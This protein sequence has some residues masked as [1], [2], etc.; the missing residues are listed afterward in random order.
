MSTIAELVVGGSP[1][2]WEN[3]GFSLLSVSADETRFSLG[4]VVLVVRQAFPPG[5][6]S[7]TLATNESDV[8][9]DITIGDITI[10]GVATH[11]VGQAEIPKIAAA[12][13]GAIGCLGVDHVVIRT[14][15]LDIT[16]DAITHATGAPVKRVRDAG[17]G[18]QQAFHKLGDVVVEVVE[19]PQRVEATHLWGFVVNVADINGDAINLYAYTATSQM[20]KSYYTTT[21]FNINSTVTGTS[22]GEI[23][24]SMSAANTSNLSSG[25]Y[26]YD[27]KITSPELIVTRVVEGIVTVLPSVT[28]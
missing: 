10:D 1:E 16:C 8:V 3:F 25:R 28:R 22:N 21:A 11:V 19:S 5:M 20:R 26:V 18:V 12:G 7:W 6:V 4:D 2:P 15:S 13:V 14:N 23:T 17:S 9:G 27:L 24:L